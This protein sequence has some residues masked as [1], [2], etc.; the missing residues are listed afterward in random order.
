MWNAAHPVSSTPAVRSN[1]REAEDEERSSEDE[2][3]ELGKGSCGGRGGRGALR[4]RK[5]GGQKGGNERGEKRGGGKA[6]SNSPDP[7]R[8]MSRLVTLMVRSM[9]PILR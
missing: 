9:T 2:D 1:E 8:S 6:R 3:T 5:R 7:M 4:G